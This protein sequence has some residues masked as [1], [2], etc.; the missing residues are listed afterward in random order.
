MDIWVELLFGNPIG[1]ASVI[2]L[3]STIGIGIYILVMFW[4]KS[5]QKGGES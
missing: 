5:G 1:L 3:A 2:A 4:V